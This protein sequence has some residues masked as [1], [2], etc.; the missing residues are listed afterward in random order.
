MNQNGASYSDEELKKILYWLYKL[1]ELDYQLYNGQKNETN[2]KS[3]NLHESI[4]RRAK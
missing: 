2:E 3:N 1:G 4:N